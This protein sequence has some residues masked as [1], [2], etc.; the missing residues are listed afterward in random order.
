MLQQCQARHDIDIKHCNINRSISLEI[1]PG[2]YGY[3]IIEC[4]H[5]K[6]F[7]RHGAMTSG[8]AWIITS[9]GH[10]EVPTLEIQ[11][12]V[13]LDAKKMSIDFASTQP[14]KGRAVIHQME[15]HTRHGAGPPCGGQP[16]PN[17]HYIEGYRDL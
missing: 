16:Y 11:Q 6:R 2:V 17:Q 12:D 3:H 5:F 8:P 4:C 10:P 7:T 15:N 14:S 1:S 9:N 13:I